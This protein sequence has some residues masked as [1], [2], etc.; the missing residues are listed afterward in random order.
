MMIMSTG[1]YTSRDNQKFLNTTNKIL[2]HTVQQEN[3]Y[4]NFLYL[5]LSIDLTEKDLDLKD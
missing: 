2:E 5:R 1:Q 3:S 4:K